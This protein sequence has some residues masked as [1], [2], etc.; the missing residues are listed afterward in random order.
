MYHLKI[1]S[2]YDNIIYNIYNIV[3]YFVLNIYYLYLSHNILYILQ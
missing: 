2:V 1:N 3:I